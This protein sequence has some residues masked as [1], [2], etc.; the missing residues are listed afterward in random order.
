M[1]PNASA[2]ALRRRDLDGINFSSPGG[3]KRFN[4]HQPN[5]PCTEYCCAI[6]GFQAAL[7]HRMQSDRRGLY[8]SALFVA[9]LIRQL[10]HH[11]FPITVNAEKPPPPPE[12]P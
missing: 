1:A 2:L 8:Q 9:Q 3:L 5:G 4:S 10:M 7:T 12:R 11:V 6:T